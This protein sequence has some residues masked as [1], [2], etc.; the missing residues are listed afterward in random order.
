MNEARGLLA[1]LS[2]KI[3]LDFAREMNE[4]SRVPMLVRAS[5]C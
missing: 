4:Q 1:D 3:G 5:A 2:G